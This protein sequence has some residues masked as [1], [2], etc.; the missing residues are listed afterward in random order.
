MGRLLASRVRF[1]RLCIKA[2]MYGWVRYPIRRAVSTTALRVASGIPGFPRRH[3]E[4]VATET[5][6]REA[7][8]HM[9][10]FMGFNNLPPDPM[11]T[12]SR[13]GRG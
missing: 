10:T 4:T 11:A 1:R 9:H 13:G 5:L 8:S 2:E 7:T 3:F 6:A 12:T